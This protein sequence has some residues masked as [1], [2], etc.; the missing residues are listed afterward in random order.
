MEEGGRGDE[1][2]REKGDEEREMEEDGQIMFTTRQW[3][4]TIVRVRD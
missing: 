1:R 2:E 3:R 4:I